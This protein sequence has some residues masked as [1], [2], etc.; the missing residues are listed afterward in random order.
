MLLFCCGGDVLLV[1]FCACFQLRRRLSACQLAVCQWQ[2]QWQCAAMGAGKI[3]ARRCPLV[4]GAASA[5]A[6]ARPPPACSQVQ[7]WQSKHCK[8][9]SSAARL[10][11]PAAL[12]P[13]WPACQG[14]AT[15]S[16]ALPA[17]H[18][19]HLLIPLQAAAVSRA[20][21]ALCNA[22]SKARVAE[23]ELASV[24]AYS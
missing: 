11:Q 6:A 16:V 4:P 20:P 18:C 21:S 22:G 14:C 24:P 23:L 15:A 3:A 5:C 12:Q 19:Q 8:P 1:L 10:L 17:Q 2:W 9:R 7:L 13:S